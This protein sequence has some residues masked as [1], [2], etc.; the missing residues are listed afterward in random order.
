MLHGK[1]KVHCLLLCICIWT[2][3]YFILAINLN[4]N[5]LRHI[6]KF[7]Y[8]SSEFDSTNNHLEYW[9]Y[10][11]KIN[12]SVYD[13]FSRNSVLSVIFQTKKGHCSRCIY[14]NKLF[15][16]DF[17]GK[18]KE[19]AWH[20]QFHGVNVLAEVIYDPHGHCFVLKCQLPPDSPDR[21]NITGD[22]LGEESLVYSNMGYYKLDG[23]ETKLNL[24]ACTMVNPL[25]TK[26]QNIKEWVAYHYLQGI[27]H[28]RIYSDG[29][30]ELLQ[31]A[32]MS[33]IQ[34]KV[35]E[36][37]NWTWPDQGFH[38][39]QT[40]MHSCLYRYR[41]IARWVAFFDIDEFF[42]AMEN[43][44][45]IEFLETKSIN[46][47][48]VT[49]LMVRF[50]PNESGLLTQLSHKR[51]LSS[52]PAG[53]RSKCI[54]QPT[55][56]HNMGVHEITNGGASYIADPVHELRLNHYRNELDI[57]ITTVDYSMTKYGPALYVELRRLD[58]ISL[59]Y[60]HITK[61]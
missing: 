8:N 45:I 21:F 10:F 12:P 41:S 1:Y 56:V 26:T 61:D 20:C 13:A 38:H 22:A 9:R 43:L 36:V 49:A 15:L 7:K 18:K 59:K 27:K 5:S 60:S 50:L 24:A 3:Q 35:V 42:Q 33:Y 17:N 39:Q 19:V 58:N 34:E 2:L 11:S 23:N 52:L 4:K 44:T 57:P 53:D 32:L 54:V 31:I 40:Q 46:F 37:I 47:A 6:N 16:L 30:P 48:G 25:K 28:F 55:H 51:S 14:R 29:N